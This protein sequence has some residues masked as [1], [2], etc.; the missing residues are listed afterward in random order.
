M[1][2]QNS[3]FKILNPKQRGFGIIEIIVAI[4]IMS[5]ALFAISEVSILYMKQEMQHK[6]TLKATY[7]AEEAI[8]ASRSVR[9]QGW[10]TNIAT[11]TM[12]SPYYP[13]ISGGKWTLTATNPGA[14]DTIYNRQVVIDDVSRNDGDNI[15]TSGGANDPNTKKITTTISW[16]NKSVSLTTYIT[17]IYNN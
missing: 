15:L 3:K 1:I 11:L 12:G 14:I 2:D 16:N 9:D 10:S 7:L 6:Q 4:A 8:E 13:V 17:N 5:I